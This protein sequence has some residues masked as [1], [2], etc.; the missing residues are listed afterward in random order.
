MRR[1]LTSA[2]LLSMCCAASPTSAQDGPEQPDPPAPQGEQEQPADAPPAATPGPRSDAE[3]LAGVKYFPLQQGRRW[4]YR[5]AFKIQPASEGEGSP[6]ESDEGEHRLDVYVADPVTIDDKLAAALEWKLDQDLA[7]RSYF[8]VEGDYLRCVKRLQGFSEH[9]KEFTLSPAQPVVPVEPKTGQAWTWEGKAGPGPGKQSF[10]IL[11]EEQ[12]ET[13]AGIFK[14]IVIE[15]SFDGEDD[16][17]GTTTRWLAP[18]VGIVKE[19]SEVRTAVQVFRT[20]GVLVR[21]EVP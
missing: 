8:R 1:I 12:L 7:Q 13:P 4:T 11:R 19:V 14:A 21:Y 15:A 17:R 6:T 10:K 16:S 3:A 2:L 18:G 20:E 9:V 5:V